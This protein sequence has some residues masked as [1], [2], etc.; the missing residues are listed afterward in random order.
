MWIKVG[1]R[2]VAYSVSFF[3]AGF[4]M[5][6][7]L[8][9]LVPL[10]VQVAWAQLRGGCWVKTQACDAGPTDAA[11]WV[12]RFLQRVVSMFH[13]MPVDAVWVRV[14]CAGWAPELWMGGWMNA[15]CTV[16]VTMIGDTQQ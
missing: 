15:W 4:W 9:R 13:H 12:C 2:L 16:M 5:W 1:S 3:D 11:M 7:W 14:V 8:L 6:C 10:P